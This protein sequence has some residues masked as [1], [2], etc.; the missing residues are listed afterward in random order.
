MD[1]APLK[2]NP[3]LTHLVLNPASGTGLLFIADRLRK[4]RRIYIDDVQF[5]ANKDCNRCRAIG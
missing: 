2:R 3:C 4:A 1:I 5:F